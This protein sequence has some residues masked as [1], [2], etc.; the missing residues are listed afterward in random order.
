MIFVFLI[1]VVM[2][3]LLNGLA[4]SDTGIIREEAEIHGHIC[5]VEAISALEA[6][7]LGDPSLLWRGPRWLSYLIP[8]CGLRQRLGTVLGI[9]ALFSKLTGSSGVLLFYTS[10]PDKRLVIHPNR[11]YITCS[12]C[13]HPTKDVGVEVLKSSKQL[14]LRLSARQMTSSDIKLDQL[15]RQQNQLEEAQTR[16]EH[17]MDQILNCLESMKTIINKV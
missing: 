11:K 12:D 15:T 7:L 1:V 10:L 16:M 4:V 2:M 6:T 13:S 14:I 3:N 17:K 8:S 9:R 5:R